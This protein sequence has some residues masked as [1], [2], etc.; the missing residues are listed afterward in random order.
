MSDHAERE[1]ESEAA[2]GAGG[3]LWHRSVQKV[4]PKKIIIFKSLSFCYF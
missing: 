1:E 2:G 4:F 3:K